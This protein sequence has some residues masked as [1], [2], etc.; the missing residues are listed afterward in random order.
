M[1]KISRVF[2]AL[3]TLA[4]MVLSLGRMESRGA[5]LEGHSNRVSI[6]LINDDDLQTFTLQIENLL[7]TNG[8]RSFVNASG[9]GNSVLVRDSD[10]T[11]AVRLIIESPLVQNK[12]IIITTKGQ[13]WVPAPSRNAQGRS[14][15][16][17]TSEREYIA[18][19]SNPRIYTNT[20]EVANLLSSNGIIP[21]IS[22]GLGGN[23]VFVEEANKSAAITLIGKASQGDHRD[24]TL[25]VASEL[26]NAAQEPNKIEQP[27]MEYGR[28]PSLIHV[29]TLRDTQ[30]YDFLMEV[31]NMLT[32]NGIEGTILPSASLAGNDI[33]VGKSDVE[34]AVR[35]IAK[36]SQ[37]KGREFG[38]KIADKYQ[39]LVREN[40]N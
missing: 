10:A 27:A 36:A 13:R 2:T 37:L 32:T 7:L 26:K 33:T 23:E 18:F 11:A 17:T 3:S 40:G 24:V 19:I 30:Y 6:A 25:A 8:I 14:Q 22:G 4:L 28:H 15:R 5:D 39:Y 38:I 29:G 9:P 34:T 20:L 35:L 21:R 31:F 12:S 16:S 1:T